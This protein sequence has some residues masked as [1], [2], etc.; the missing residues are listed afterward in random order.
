MTPLGWVGAHE[1]HT[2]LSP[3]KRKLN[4]IRV[5]EMFKPQQELKRDMRVC[6]RIYWRIPQKGG[7]PPL[8]PAQYGYPP[9]K[10]H[11]CRNLASA[12]ASNLSGSQLLRALLTTA[13]CARSA[14]EDMLLT[15]TAFSMTKHSQLLKP[16]GLSSLK[17]VRKEVAVTRGTAR[18]YLESK[19]MRISPPRRGQHSRWL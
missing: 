5:Q 14:I 15:G 11:P 3:G 8:K 13:D 6:L 1:R 9:K 10:G 18:E 17:D 4:H 12:D 2:V 19:E 7:S 16:L